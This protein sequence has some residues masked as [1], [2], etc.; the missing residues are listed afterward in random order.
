MIK[1]SKS[2]L[3]LLVA[4][5]CST[6]SAQQLPRDQ[7]GAMPVNVSH[8]SGKWVIK[9]KHNQVTLTESNLAL[10]IQAGPAQWN[11]MPSIA[12]DMLVKSR[13]E[14]ISLRIADAK[15]ITIVPFDTGFK[16]GLKISASGW[17]QK[18]IE[19]RGVATKK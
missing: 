4:F 11:L 18:G 5:V 17:Q 16:T 6:V 19:D 13:G 12:G 1:I 14:D 10:A 3:T 15:K 9:G 8:N 2:I 7:W